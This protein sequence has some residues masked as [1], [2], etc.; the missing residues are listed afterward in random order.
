MDIQKKRSLMTYLILVV[1]AIIT[2]Y[3][4]QFLSQQYNNIRVWHWDSFLMIA[5]G[6]FFILLQKE[7]GLPEVWDPEVS[8]YNRIGKPVLTGILF[9]IADVIAVKIMQH[10]QPYTEM[11]PFLQPFPYSVFLYTSGAFDVEITYRLIPITLIML[12]IGRMLLKGKYNSQLLIV[13]AILTGFIEPLEQLVTSPIWFA[14]Y[15]MLT[16]FAMNFIQGWNLGRYGFLSALF[17]R[18]GHYL[19]W[20]I[21]LG[22]YVEYFELAR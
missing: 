5:I 4:G 21:L 9:G 22:I 14:V 10:P 7:A 17:V 2:M 1:I 12:L 20:H 8:N 16:G 19:V 11:P 6:L 13:L 15:A 18:L 3:Y